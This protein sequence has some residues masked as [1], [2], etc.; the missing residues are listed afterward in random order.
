MVL[1][2]KELYLKSV[3]LC[4]GSNHPVSTSFLLLLQ[5][6]K[7]ILRSKFAFLLRSHLYHR[8]I[9]SEGVALSI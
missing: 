1:F 2:Q 8:R 7:P 5:V 4:R 3:E 6:H 9:L